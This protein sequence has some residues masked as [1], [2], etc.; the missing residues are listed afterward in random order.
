MKKREAAVLFSVTI[1]MALGI[2][3]DTI[4][5]GNIP[6]IFET[7]FDRIQDL[8]LVIYQIQATITTLG[9]ALITILSGVSGDIVYGYSTARYILQ[10]RPKILKHKNI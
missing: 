10:I 1:V 8:E 9:I 6:S 4:F 7:R 3:F 5:L 2:C